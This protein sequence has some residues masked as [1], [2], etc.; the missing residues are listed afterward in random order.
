VSNKFC[1]CVDKAGALS[2]PAVRQGRARHLNACRVAQ[3]CNLLVSPEITASR[4]DFSDTTGAWRLRRFSVQNLPAPFLFRRLWNFVRGSSIKA[5]L[6]WL[7]L[8]RAG[9]YRRISFCGTSASASAL[10]VWDGLPITNRQYGRL[11]IC[12]TRP[13]YALNICRHSAHPAGRA[14][15]SNDTHGMTR[16]VYPVYDVSK[17]LCRRTPKLRSTR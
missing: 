10:E 7:R 5:A 6:L 9:L 4:D 12:A 17:P 1:N 2:A 13:R 11:Q 16:P 15:S 14:R 8:R 3:I